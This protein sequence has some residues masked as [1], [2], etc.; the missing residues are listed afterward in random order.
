MADRLAP[1]D[2]LGPLPPG[3]MLIEASAGTGK[4]W[5][6]SALVARLIVE[7][8]VPAEQLLLMTYTRAATAELRDRIRARLRDVAL[9]LGQRDASTRAWDDPIVGYLADTDP[10]TLAARGERARLALDGV[11]AI[12]IYTL[13]AFAQH[14][15]TRFALAGDTPLGLALLE[16][17]GPLA[18]DVTSDWLSTRRHAA[19]PDE[20]AL[21][22]VA[23]GGA[24]GVRSL[25]SVAVRVELAIDPAQVIAWRPALDDFLAD[26]RALQRAWQGGQREHL[27]TLIAAEQARPK[28]AL[29]GWSRGRTTEARLR[30]ADLA[31]QPGSSSKKDRESFA[32]HLVDGVLD[33][34]LDEQAPDLRAHLHAVSALDERY[35]ALCVALRHDFIQHVRA[36]F[37]ELL[38]EG[39]LATFDDFVRQLAEAVVRQG[40]S[41]PL[42]T[43]LR[44]QYRAV[45]VDEFQDTDPHQWALLRGAFLSVESGVTPP[46]LVLV[47]DPKQ[48]IYSFRGADVYVYQDAREACPADRRFTMAKNYRSDRPYVEA[49]NHWLGREGRFDLDFVDYVSIEAAH[50]ARI[51]L[52]GAPLTVRWFDPEALDA[53]APPTKEQAASWS[54]AQV[55]IDIAAMLDAQAGVRPRDIAVLVRGHRHA[56]LVRGALSAAGIP[57]VLGRGISVFRDEAAVTLLGW[58]D[59]V[60]DPSRDG[61]ARAL[62]LTPLLGWG[63]EALR[64]A[65][66]DEPALWAAVRAQIGDQSRV[67]AESGVVAAF[68]RAVAT[69]QVWQRLLGV[70]EGERTATN[71]RHLV[72]LLHRVERQDRL[73]IAGLRRWLAA[74]IAEPRLE[75][76][77]AEQ[78]L[79]SDADAVVIQTA[80]ASKGL[81][82]PIV[83]VPF[84]WSTPA[85]VRPGERAV[86]VRSTAS[87]WTAGSPSYID[88]VDRATTEQLREEARLLYVAVTRAQ[89]RCIIYAVPVRNYA[90]S[91]LGMWLH[92]A[93]EPFVALRERLAAQ[94]SEPAALARE[95]EALAAPG[96]LDVTFVEQAPAP[97]RW[98]GGSAALVDGLV[99]P[100]PYPARALDRTWWSHSY[101]SFVR[102]QSKTLRLA[103]EPA[104][105]P[106]TERVPLPLGAFPRGRQPGL[107]LHS[108]LENLDFSA[109]GGD[110]PVE[111]AP[112]ERS[113]AELVAQLGHRYGFRDDTVHE[114]LVAALPLLVTTPLGGAFGATRLADIP[115]GDR[116]DELAFD[117]PLAGG[118]AWR[119]GAA[120]VRGERLLEAFAT[121]GAS[122]WI[123]DAYLAR[124]RELRVGEL[125]GVLTGA[126]DMV[127]RVRDADG[128]LRYWV[129]DWKSNDLGAH[130]AHAGVDAY[131]PAAMAAEMAPDHYWLQA[132]LYLVAL[133]RYL[134]T[135]VP[136]YHYETHIGGAA[137]LFLRGMIGPDTPQFDGLSAGV[138]SFRPSWAVIEAMSA[139]LDAPAADEVAP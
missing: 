86:Q 108:V 131:Q 14:A 105:P 120:T 32:K 43:A 53:K 1:F 98:V 138:L 90:D 111:R 119:P 82:F 63:V 96:L 46:W 50:P 78:R 38:D 56:E 37:V 106:D 34:W 128:Q 122:T 35:D 132:H 23:L 133:D 112:G 62:A 70:D 21:I 19:S 42:A 52:D 135:R 75:L 97:A 101:S 26:L 60:H 84:A 25:A 100:P 115:V 45:L 57:N 126:I 61:P 127:C 30:S 116:L 36:R 76:E 10:V 8:G 24:A 71:L 65:L 9:A 88:V 81:E 103:D 54:V 49:C 41:G 110:G 44:L 59:A 2:V 55:V 33:A 20:L 125:A 104:A 17:A 91:P 134:R 12:G 114:Q 118:D 85:V 3:P 18:L 107:Y 51:A 39:E 27:R 67:F 79:A 66:E 69:W 123:D 102:G 47:G 87:L 109:V 72:E 136:D 64:Y 99:A 89:H 28:H 7:H 92:G 73:A 80:H 137:N 83:F 124:V 95:V 4:T 121:F 77:G 5:S 15:L 68:D 6:L 31:H 11:D 139:A 22:D 130:S 29:K 129:I 117:L 40:P 58:L 93:G 13:H 113:L 16:D 48:A 94:L 74:R